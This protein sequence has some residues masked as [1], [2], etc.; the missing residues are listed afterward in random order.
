[1]PTC[2]VWKK[3]VYSVIF[4]GEKLEGFFKETFMYSKVYMLYY[5]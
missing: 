3:Q 1:M 4:W 2:E 5:L